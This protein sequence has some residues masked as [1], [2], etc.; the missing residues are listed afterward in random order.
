MLSSNRKTACN[1]IA[2]AVNKCKALARLCRRCKIRQTVNKSYVCI[3]C[4]DEMAAV[5]RECR[6]KEDASCSSK[7]SLSQ[8]GVSGSS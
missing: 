5:E 3:Y 7:C 6:P 2:R 1:K 4:L 8:R